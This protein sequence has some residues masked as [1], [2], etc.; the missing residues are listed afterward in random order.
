MYD[1]KFVIPEKCEKNYSEQELRILKKL[2]SVGQG[3]IDLYKKFL[4]EN[5]MYDPELEDD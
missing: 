1:N 2:T 4:S 3:H 5:H